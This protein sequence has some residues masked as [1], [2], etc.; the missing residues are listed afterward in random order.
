MRCGLCVIC[1]ECDGGIYFAMG[2]D[3][4]Y[5][6]MQR[7]CINYLADNFITLNYSVSDDLNSS[8][9]LII[10][11]SSCIVVF[12]IDHSSEVCSTTSTYFYTY[13][14]FALKC[15][16]FFQF[17]REMLKLKFYLLVFNTF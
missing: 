14:P 9:C 16:H 1:Q 10:V 8:V 6:P 7:S 11:H 3:L 2:N 12:H 13:G 4:Y 5:K 17:F 15:I